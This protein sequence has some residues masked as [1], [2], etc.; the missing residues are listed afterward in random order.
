MRMLFVPWP[1]TLPAETLQ[2]YEAKPAGAVAVMFDSGQK[3]ALSN[4]IAGAA[5]EYTR[6]GTGSLVPATRHEVHLPT[7]AYPARP[8]DK[9]GVARVVFRSC[10]YRDV[11]S[12]VAVRGLGERHIIA[13]N[14]ADARSS[15]YRRA[16]LPSAGSLGKIRAV[17][18][19]P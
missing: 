10:A 15:R 4:V 6:T 5:M 17:I 3:S 2:T 19:K 8:K 7:A 11:R 18:A 1:L 14:S 13:S 16:G 9:L 12:V